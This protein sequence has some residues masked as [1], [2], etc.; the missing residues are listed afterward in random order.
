VFP[1]EDFADL[2][3]QYRGR[4]SIPATVMAAV[5]TLQTLHDCSDRETAEAVC[6]D[7]RWKVAI[8]AS[9]TDTGF[10]A[11]TLVYWRRR[12]A[13][14]DRPHRINEAGAPSPSTPCRTCLERRHPSQLGRRAPNRCGSGMAEPVTSMGPAA[15]ASRPRPGQPL[16][17]SCLVSQPSNL[18]KLR[19]KISAG[20][21]T[22]DDARIF[23]AIR[24]YLST[25]T[26]A[27]RQHSP[28]STPRPLTRPPASSP[29]DKS[30]YLKPAQTAT[31]RHCR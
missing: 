30:G 7:L 20:L 25:A 29:T 15:H 28:A 18:V 17:A 10:D 13:R 31:V 12:I 4:P 2:F 21:R 8:G 3:S 5:V 6:F 11:S 16:C 19:Q 1:D 27:G 22:M 26:Q 9:L 14:S 23:C 24:S